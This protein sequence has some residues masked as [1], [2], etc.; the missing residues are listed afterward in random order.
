MCTIYFLFFFQGPQRDG[1]S[2]LADLMFG[3]RQRDT[4]LTKYPVRNRQRVITYAVTIALQKYDPKFLEGLKTHLHKLYPLFREI[5]GT[6]TKFQDQKDLGAV[7][8]IKIFS[9]TQ[10]LREIN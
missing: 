9:A 8:N 5:N 4:G 6:E 10:I 2:S 3:L 7:L 1:F